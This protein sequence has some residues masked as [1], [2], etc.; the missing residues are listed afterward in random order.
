VVNAH[1]TPHQ[2]PGMALE[3]VMDKLEATWADH[4]REYSQQAS[5]KHKAGVCRL[6]CIS[7]VQ[8]ACCLQEACNLGNFRAI[9]WCRAACFAKSCCGCEPVLICT[10]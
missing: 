8:P 3:L 6:R 10:A 2:K 4:A 9:G 7:P 1:A 5:A